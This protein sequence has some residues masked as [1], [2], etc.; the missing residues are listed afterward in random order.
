MISLGGPSP[1]KEL[2]PEKNVWRFL[3]KN[4]FPKSKKA[5][6]R[7]LGFLKYYPNNVPRLSERLAPF[8]KI[9]NCQENFIVTNEFVQQ[10]EEID[11][12]LDKCCNL[13]LQ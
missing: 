4:N 12:A 5:L 9:L 2:N 6:E 10:F 7:Y 3:E 13:A 8:Y 11:E 1:L